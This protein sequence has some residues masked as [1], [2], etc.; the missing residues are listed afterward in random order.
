MER[1]G[2]WAQTFTGKQFWPLDPKAEEVDLMDI[3]HSLASQPR[4]NGHCITFYSVAQHSVLVSKIVPPSQ[5]LAAL[6]HDASESYTGDIISPLK[7][8]LPP[9]FK[10]IELNI[11]HAIFKKFNIDIETIDHAAIKKAD[12]IALVTEM[13]DVME[14]P[15]KKWNEDGL[16]EPSP[17]K[18]I[19]L[20]PQEAEKLFLE[21][22][23][24]LTKNN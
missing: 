7:R 20:P 23:E 2:D 15:P 12:K 11:D 4:F 6:F 10:Q 24:E 22:Y 18:I 16:F 8:F 17:E 9:E 1:K 14:K 19:P 21:R 5:A 13:R 3:A